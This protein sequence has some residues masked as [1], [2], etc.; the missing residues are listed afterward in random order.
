[1]RTTPSLRIALLT[2]VLLWTLP[3]PASAQPRDSRWTAGATAGMGRTW[4][5][6]GQIGSGALAGGYAGWR[7]LARTDA[8]VSVE[9]LRHRRT[10]GHFQAI[11]HTALVEG[12]LT[13][14]FGPQA[15]SGYVLGGVAL[16]FHTG[17]AG[18]PADGLVVRTESTQR[19]VV[20]GGGLTFR[21][22]ERLEM[23]PIVKIV[24]LAAD[25]DSDPASAAM[26]GFRIGTR[27]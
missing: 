11:G 2:L 13:R 17:T 19:G 7:W 22:G 10:G 12:V 20:A 25:R 5:D 26:V 6:E 18:F 8:E 21:V 3:D 4:D 9:I 24:L 23:G 16:G 15:A 14:R 1:M 27:R